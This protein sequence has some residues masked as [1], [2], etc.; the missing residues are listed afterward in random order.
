M[1]EWL[2]FNNRSDLDHALADHIAGRL[3]DG[4]EK[5]GKAYLVV[6]GGRTPANLFAML[7]NRK[8]DWRQVVILLADERWV[9]LD[10]K[11]RNE[12]LVRDTL[13]AGN[14]C[15][16]T[17]L[18]LITNIDDEAVNSATL[19]STLAT[20]P[21]FDVVILGM[22]EDGH[23]ASLFPCADEIFDGLTTVT[24]ALM[25]EPKTAPHRRISLSKRRLID[26]R[27]G[28]IHIVG[29]KKRAICE[30]ASLEDPLRY[31]I[32][33]FLGNARFDCWWAP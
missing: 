7:G 15:G 24:G 18:S 4:I 20:L 19:N 12:R 28:A 8:L 2:D 10:H 21:S 14:A 29:D 9:A 32:S 25:I 13:L 11:D 5:R 33:A 30:A 31:P 26:A 6:S 16:A 1:S 3:A 17:L 23:T 22:G 27:Y